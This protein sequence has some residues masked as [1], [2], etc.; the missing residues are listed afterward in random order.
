MVLI[1]VKKKKNMTKDVCRKSITNK[2]KFLIIYTALL[3]ILT[4]FVEVKWKFARHG[5]VE[6]RLEIRCPPVFELLRSSAIVFAHP[7]YPRE[8]VLENKK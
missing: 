3:V 1:L 4:Y 6:T 8:Y 2:A 7:R 5:T